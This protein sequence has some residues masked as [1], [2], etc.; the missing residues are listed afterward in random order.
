MER[1]KMGSMNRRNILV[2]NWKIQMKKK[3]KEANGWE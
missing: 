1:E 3:S 2:N